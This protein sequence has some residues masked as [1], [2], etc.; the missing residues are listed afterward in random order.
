MTGRFNVLPAADRDLDELADYLARE[1]GI[2]TA[3][4]FFDASFAT[5]GRLADMTGIGER[6]PSANPRLDGLR[7][8]RIEDFPNHLLFYRASDGG[9]DIIRILHGARDI[10]SI[11]ESDYGDDQTP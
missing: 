11:L 6:W 8:W 4:R 7:V 2:E 1:A 5:F 10:D 9:I 3:Y